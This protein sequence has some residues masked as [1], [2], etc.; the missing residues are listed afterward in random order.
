MNYGFK[1]E[2]QRSNKR[3]RVGQDIEAKTE[4]AREARMLRAERQRQRRLRQEQE[5]RERYIIP[6]HLDLDELLTSHLE[7]ER[8]G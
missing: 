4:Q 2:I 6:E 7:G 8:H 1:N 3:L 5:D